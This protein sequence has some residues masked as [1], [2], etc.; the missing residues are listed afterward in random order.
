MDKNVYGY[1]IEGCKVFEGFDGTISM[2]GVDYPYVE[3][4]IPEYDDP[5]V[6]APTSLQTAMMLDSED[7]N[8]VPPLGAELL[9]ETIFFY[10]EDSEFTS[11]ENIKKFLEEH[12]DWFNN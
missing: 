8:A 11:K 10:V 1:D 9:D 6:I 3:L 12:C 2:G 4:D 5:Q 7:E